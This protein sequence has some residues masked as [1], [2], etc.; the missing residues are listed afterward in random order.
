M[1]CF[2]NECYRHIAEKINCIYTIILPIRTDLSYNF[3]TAANVLLVTPILL[4]FLSVS[5]LVT[6]LE[7]GRYVYNAR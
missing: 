3:N 2:G 5:C 7:V 4:I 6:C 1:Y